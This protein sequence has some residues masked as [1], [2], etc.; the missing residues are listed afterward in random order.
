MITIRQYQTEDAKHALAI[1]SQAILDIDQS[2]YSF[3]QKRAWLGAIGS[4]LKHNI[5]N[6][7]QLAIW[8]QRLDKT[9]PLIATIENIVIGFIEYLID[10]DQY[11]Q[12]KSGDAY[13]D[14]LYIHPKYQRQGVAQLLYYEVGLSLIKNN[15]ANVWVHASK[16]AHPFF[17][18]QGFEVVEPQ[19][20][21]RHNVT[22][23]RYLMCKSI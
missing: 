22:L 6:P 21:K 13:V 5:D 2:Q 20:V 16:L 10:Q 15:I 7:R 18:K 17:L 19:A 1:F 8:Q 11:G 12:F 9:K 4:D 14:C 23:E 3:A